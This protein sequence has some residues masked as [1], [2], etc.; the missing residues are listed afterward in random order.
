[1]LTE[2]QKNLVIDKDRVQ[3]PA[4]DFAFLRAKGIELV[5]QFA[6]R[7]WTDYNLHDPG[8]TILEYLCYALTDIAYRTSFP[9]A[10][11]LA[12]K[13][14]I[15][16]GAKN[17]FISKEEA[18]CCSPIT[19]NDYRKLLID[20]VPGVDNAWIEPITSAYAHRY[21]KGMYRVII[22]PSASLVHELTQFDEAGQEAIT[23]KLIRSV[24]ETLL[25]HRS[26]GDFYD[27]FQVLRPQPVYIRAELMIERG[28]PPKDVLA[29]V[30]QALEQVLNPPVPVYTETELLA[31]GL[32]VE[33]I[34]SGPLLQRGIIRDEDLRNRITELDPFRLVKAISKLDGVA[35]VRKLE[36]SG[37]GI[38]Y[39]T[40][41]LR[42]KEGHF[43]FLAIDEHHPQIKL[44]YD[45]Y[46]LHIQEETALRKRLVQGKPVASFTHQAAGRQ[47]RGA[48]KSLHEYTSIQT[49]F[50][51]LY[52]ISEAGALRNQPAASIAKSR[53]LKA[54]LMLFE[55]L[56]ANALSQLAGIGELFSTDIADGAR[57]TYFFQPLYQ[58]PDAAY[59]LKAFTDAAAADHPRGWE[60]F[61]QDGANG[62]MQA[63]GSFIETDG[64]Y[65][66]RK[67]RAFDHL[68]A[69]FNIAVEKH[70]VALYEFY[71][72]GQQQRGRI[73]AELQWKAAILNNLASFT[74]NRVKADNYFSVQE[75]E[76]QEEGYGRKMSLL[77]HIK[78]RSRR[79]L[80][81]VLQTYGH[82]LSVR[83]HTGEDS[84]G[85]EQVPAPSNIVFK[86]QP[87]SLFRLA[88]DRT[89]YRM[90]AAATGT[91]L[92][93]RLPQ[94]TEWT[95][96]STHPDEWGAVKA[97]NKTVQLF[98]EI[99]IESEGFYLLEHV[100]LKP[101]LDAASWG[102]RFT[103][104]ANRVLIRQH[105]W[106]SFAQR[107]Q[108]VASLL[109]IAAA[110]RSGDTAHSGERLGEI[111]VF[112]DYLLSFPT[113]GSTQAKGKHPGREA[114]DYLVRSLHAFTLSSTCFYPAFDY[115]VRQPDGTV[116]AESFFD[117]RMTVVLP[118]WPARF[119][120]KG[121]REGAENRF[122]EEGPAHMKLAFLWLSLP[123]MK[124]FDDL[125]F[126]WLQ[127]MKTETAGELS[128]KLVRLLHHSTA[129]QET[130]DE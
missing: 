31:K 82:Q 101:S 130:E 118:S 129:K 47:L 87:E 119:Q 90:Q 97:L 62:L 73:D 67:K 1:M 127:A 11:M 56:L 59:L 45:H 103:D 98:R 80:S 55:Q 60:P 50:P 70:P 48:Y 121:F 71:Y 96:L 95:T 12:D 108:T 84:A 22:Q 18:L 75:D 41:V 46:P 8:V 35:S 106:Q 78:H 58:V 9:I 30:Y 81:R 29:A 10:D 24:K 113:N 20:Q 16:D 91:E 125:Y 38:D 43:P 116:L 61:K 57:S 44:Y 83:E 7:N 53:Q 88:L 74:G 14:G 111:C 13:N 124:Q 36:L 4:L 52:G 19:A 128:G 42:G 109:E 39:G 3:E 27:S 86:R 93:F 120:D 49:Q 17:F 32:A 34:Y 122:R 112:S 54:Y 5:Q 117:F 126:D 85:G 33:D 64:Q 92:Q 66:D 104:A 25:A 94:E 28:V 37:D 23:Q 6:G 40:Q 102:F 76:S 79:R 110:H 107:E 114:I 77:L 72:G 89:N 69:R 15:I 63:M 51:A 99:S 115:T 68:L 21:C 26:I 100:L 2:H 65:K 105:T 123:A